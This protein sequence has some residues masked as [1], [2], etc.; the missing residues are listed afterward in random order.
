MNWRRFVAWGFSLFVSWHARAETRY[1]VPVN[2]GA[3]PPYTNWATAATTI[4]DAVHASAAGD[5]VWVTDGVYTV[6]APLLVTNGI[7]IRSVNGRGPVVVDGQDQRRC[8]ELG[9]ADAQLDGLVLVRGAAVQGGGIYSLGATITN[10]AVYACRASNSAAG[11]YLAGGLLVDSDVSSNRIISSSGDALWGAGICA[12]SSAVVR[13]CRVDTNSLSANNGGNVWGGGLYLENA[14]VEHSSVRANYGYSSLDDAEGG[15]ICAFEDS[16]VVSCVVES[17]RLTASS[18]VAAGGGISAYDSMVTGTV[19]RAN[20]ARAGTYGNGYGG[21]IM[22]MNADIAG[23]VVDSNR[24]YA[25]D[26]QGI[27]GGIYLEAGHLTDTAVRSNYLETVNDNAYGGG[28]GLFAGSLMESCDVSGN[29]VEL[30]DDTVYGVGVYCVN[31]TVSVCRITGN[32]DISAAGGSLGGGVYVSGAS[33]VRSCFMAGNFA[34]QGGGLCL[35][36]SAAQV[37]NCTAVSNQAYYGGG[38]RQS[39]GLLLN[40]ILVDNTTLD[41]NPNH[42]LTGGEAAYSCS[43]PPLPGE[44][45]DE[46]RPQFVNA[47]AGNYALLPGSPGVDDGFNEDWMTNATDLA[48]RA[49]IMKATVDRGAYELDPASGPLACNPVANPAEGFYPLQVVF[50]AAVAGADT[51]GLYYGISTAMGPLRSRATDWP[52]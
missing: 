24:L 4:Q 36:N 30:E 25:A 28:V 7:A 44:G 5:T 41:S 39:A 16:R 9:S 22:G 45:N 51:A 47:A 26:D 12:V 19:V 17:N 32:M 33:G 3:A 42:Y 14:R 27:G 52:W 8:F 50:T 18:S 37:I 48:G 15:G 23:C 29:Q 40:S 11:V 46:R 35:V 49:R 1:V 38:L 20:H 10:C 6:T 13:G 21:G 2:P 34:V 43:A 31:S